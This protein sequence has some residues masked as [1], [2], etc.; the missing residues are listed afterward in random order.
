M[1]NRRCERAKIKPRATRKPRTHNQEIAPEMVLCAVFGCSNRKTRGS[2]LHFYKFPHGDA[3]SEWIRRIGRADRLPKQVFV[4]GDHF[5]D[6]DYQRNVLGD[7]VRGKH[8]HPQLKDDAV[9]SRNLPSIA[10]V[11]DNPITPR[12]SRALCRSQKQEKQMLVASI[13]SDVSAYAVL[14]DK[15][16]DTA[17]GTQHTEAGSQTDSMVE[18]GG[19]DNYLNMVND[20]KLL[21]DSNDN[22]QRENTA[23]P[24]GEMYDQALIYFAGYIAFK[25]LKSHPEFGVRTASM[26]IAVIPKWLAFLSKGGLIC[27]SD[28]LVDTVKDFEKHFDAFNGPN[29]LHTCCSYLDKLACYIRSN[30][31]FVDTPDT[32][33]STYCKTRSIIRMRFL[34]ATA[35]HDAKFRKMRKKM[36]K[37]MK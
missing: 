22:L 30:T 21:K 3:T 36:N 11:N 6:N 7:I 4:C 13:L 35:V 26:D 14:D 20:I 19:T 16:K 33:I 29:G 1:D 9:P 34:A 12:S 10:N 15:R 18:G 27:P 25:H 17:A 23:V 32:V 24:C 8:N 37:F 2:T 28:K 5:A 31:T